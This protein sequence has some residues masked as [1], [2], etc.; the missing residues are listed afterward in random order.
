[1]TTT[2]KTDRPQSPLNPTT[3]LFHLKPMVA[4]V[5]LVITGSLCVGVSAPAR[6]E[7]PIPMP[8]QGWVTSG[9]ASFGAAANI[10]TQK[11]LQH[12]KN[13]TL[14]WKS[15]NVGKDNTVQ[16]VQEK[17][18]S[19][20]ALNRIFQGSPSKILGKIQAN[21]QI[22][23]VN[24]NGIVF[25]KDSVVDTNGLVASAL[26]ISD[27]A[28][29]KGIIRVLEK[30]GNP[31]DAALDGQTGEA[32]TEVAPNAKIEVAAG[33]KIHETPRL[34]SPPA[35]RFM[36]AKTATSFW[37]RPRSVT[38]VRSRPMKKA[39]SSWW[40]VRIKSICN[41]LPATVRLPVSLSKSGRA[42]R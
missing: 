3:N 5:R 34:K 4:C 20:I 8:G 41:P 40:P 33:A 30:D 6:A 23:L 11:I 2:R 19:S 12:S 36:S 17:G 7:L 16:F 39:R 24:K 37:R 27:K 35:P 42:V 18:S 28:F 38:P 1:M 15:F 31:G 25:G 29:E 26:N 22:Y 14:N 10:N 32:D 13:A 21:G 9:S